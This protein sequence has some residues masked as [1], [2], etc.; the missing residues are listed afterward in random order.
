MY[1]DVSAL[2]TA[3]TLLGTQMDEVTVRP[4]EEGWHVRAV[5]PNHVTL[6][7]LRIGVSSFRDYEVWE[8]FGISVKDV[9][10][11]LS[12]A[13]DT[14]EITKEDRLVIRSDG[15]RYRK[16][17]LPADETMPRLP[18]PDLSTEV[19]LD[20]SRLSK[21][22]SKGDP[23]H[24]HVL[25]TV[26]DGTFTASVED[27]AQ[28]VSL[29][30]PAEDCAL[31][32]GD[33]TS[34]YPVHAWSSLLKAL[35]KGTMLDMSFDTSYPLVVKGSVDGSTFSWLVAPFLLED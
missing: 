33:A 4:S 25:F 5:S 29:E 28:S 8:E 34:A 11:A 23:K 9:L 24:G 27:D 3:F 10:D 18:T 1:V 16:R 15:L 32:T 35:P 12:T 30:I 2:R 14:A 13:S 21:L 26:K 31:L 17:L 22:V 6:V 19:M 7:D 20:T